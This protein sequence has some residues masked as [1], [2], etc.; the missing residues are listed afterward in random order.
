MPTSI[1]KIIYWW[2][3]FIIPIKYCIN[4]FIIHDTFSNE[5]LLAAIMPIFKSCNGQ[6]RELV[7]Y[8]CFVIFPKIYEKVVNFIPGF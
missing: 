3:Y 2:V 5:L 4:L 8:F 7:T 6:L 1:L